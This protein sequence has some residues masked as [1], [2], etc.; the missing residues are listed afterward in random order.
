GYGYIRAGAEISANVKKVA[1]FKEKPD[2]ETAES[3]VASGEYL[4]NSGMFLIRASTYL[5]ELESHAPDIAAASA[6]AIHDATIDGNR[7]HLQE[8]A[9][10]ACRSES[11]DFAVMEPTSMAAVVPTDPDWND[12]GSWASL[13]DIADK[14]GEGNVLQGDIAAV[15]TSG[16]YVRGTDRLIAAV[17]I[18]DTVI[19]D[20]PDAVLV[21]HKDAAQDVKAIVDRLQSE[22]RPEL[23]SDGTVHRPWGH[24]RIIDSGPGYRVLHLWLDPG[25]KTSVKE[26]RHRSEHWLV[27]AG[28]ARIT[29]GDV[30]RLVPTKESVYIPP[31]EIHRLENP[32]EDVLEVIE[33]D[34][35]TYVG[36]DDIKRHMDAYGRTERMG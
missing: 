20:T 14:D 2:A 19:V 5:K 24:F 17:G 3:Y 25:G 23:V 34:I 9:F 28:V 22:N 35:G 27:I 36:E 1:E 12:V 31:G 26:H 16:S 8:E 10:T 13:W 11:I 30:C 32:G 15:D 21:A 18:T 29:T 7:V 33:V 6:A 4:W